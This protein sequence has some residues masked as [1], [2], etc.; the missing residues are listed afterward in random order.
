MDF[1]TRAVDAS[2]WSSRTFEDPEYDE[3]KKA[4]VLAQAPISPPKEILSGQVATLVV[5]CGHEAS[6]VLKAAL[7]LASAGSFSADSL[8]V[9]FSC[10]NDI[11]S[12][13]V[14]VDDN[15]ASQLATS[16]LTSLKPKKTLVIS[17]AARWAC[18]GRPNPGILWMHSATASAKGGDP[19]TPPSFLEGAPAAFVAE[20]DLE[21]HALSA[22]TM[23][24]E[25]ISATYGDL[26]S[27]YR[28]LLEFLN[29]P[30]ADWVASE[31]EFEKQVRANLKAERA[32]GS[33]MF[34]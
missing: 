30:G 10:S 2:L 31:T 23:V 32:S 13:S 8:D 27:L 22:A 19:L 21:G 4:A 25:D 7:K 17:S 29:A 15:R 24:K 18:R 1:F 12:I 33:A 11:A 6:L 16:A 34:M 3:D 20:A 28:T 14:E 9:P 5:A 26:L